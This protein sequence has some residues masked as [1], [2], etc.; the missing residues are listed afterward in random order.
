[1]SVLQSIPVI[2]PFTVLD[3]DVDGGE[4]CRTLFEMTQDFILNSGA[5]RV[6]AHTHHPA[7]KRMLKRAGAEEVGTFFDWQKG[8]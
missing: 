2:E 8:K 7:M 3:P 6:L 4:V 5:R 1:M